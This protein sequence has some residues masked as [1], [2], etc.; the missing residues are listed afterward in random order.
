MQ[1]NKMTTKFFTDKY[2]MPGNVVTEEHA[3]SP[4]GQYSPANVIVQ[5]S[6]NYR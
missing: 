1:A 4:A 2:L 6:Y 5:T 3:L